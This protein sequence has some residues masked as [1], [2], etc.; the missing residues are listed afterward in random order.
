MNGELG[1]SRWMEVEKDGWT[2]GCC[3]DEW[4]DDDLK[5]YRVESWMCGGMDE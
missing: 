5:G 4:K 2:K 1:G 3:M